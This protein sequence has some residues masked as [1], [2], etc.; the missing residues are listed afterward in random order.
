[1]QEE[2]IQEVEKLN[3]DYDRERDVLYISFG[4]PNEADDSELLDNDIIVRYKG[5]RIIGITV[6]DFSQRA[7][8]K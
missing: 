3:I 7:E 2:G 8:Q 1:M 5:E 4:V 6:P